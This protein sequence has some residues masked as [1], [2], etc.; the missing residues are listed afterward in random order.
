MTSNHFYC[1]PNGHAGHCVSASSP[2][3]TS[4]SASLSVSTR[5]HPLAGSE[6]DSEPVTVVYHTSDL[7]SN[8]AS[9]ACEV[10]PINHISQSRR[11]AALHAASRPSSVMCDPD[12]RARSLL[13]CPSGVLRPD[14][15]LQKPNFCPC[16]TDW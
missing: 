15:K 4:V 1:D 11:K 10:Q 12:C 6:I 8:R 2:G 9:S 13:G 3:D 14:H 7:Y 5:P 16:R